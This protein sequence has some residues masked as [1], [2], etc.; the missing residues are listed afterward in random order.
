MDAKICLNGLINK[1][2]NTFNS[3]AVKR[4]TSGLWFYTIKSIGDKS[5]ELINVNKSPKYTAS[6][7]DLVFFT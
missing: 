7:L 4:F 1:F 6:L 3:L 2:P 5:Q